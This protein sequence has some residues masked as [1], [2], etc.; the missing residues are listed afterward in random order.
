MFAVQGRGG[1]AY[2]QTGALAGPGAAVPAALLHGRRIQIP[3]SGAVLTESAQ[4]LCPGR[5][6]GL[7]PS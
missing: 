1:I 5:A 4:W 3:G 6:S 7:G 2:V